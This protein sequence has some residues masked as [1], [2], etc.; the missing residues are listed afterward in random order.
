[1]SRRPSHPAVLAALAALWFTVIAAPAVA[2]T[3][4]GATTLRRAVPAGEVTGLEMAI[5]GSLAFVPGRPV[6]WWVTLYQVVRGRDLRV[7]SGCTLELSTSSTPDVS[8]ATTDARG[9]ARLS[10]APSARDDGGVWVDAACAVGRGVGVHRRFD[11]ILEPRATRSIALAA[12]PSAW[13]SPRERA[14]FGRVVDEATGLGVGDEVVELRAVYDG[15]ELAEQSVTTDATGA[16]VASMSGL[17]A[18][19][20]GTVYAHVDGGAASV[21]L[22]PARPDS[23]PSVLRTWTSSRVAAPGSRVTVSLDA[24]TRDGRPISNAIVEGP[25]APSDEPLRTDAAGRATFEWTLPSSAPGDRVLDISEFVSVASPEF[26]TVQSRVSMRLATRDLFVEVAARGGALVPGAPGRV[27]LHA[28]DAAGEPIASRHLQIELGTQRFDV[29]TDRAGVAAVDV[30][31]DLALDGTE[32]GGPTFAALHVATAHDAARACVRVDPD[33]PLALEFASPPRRGATLD[34]H[35]HRTARL[36]AGPVIVT[37]LELRADGWEPVDELVIE[38][39]ESN[40]S[41]HASPSARSVWVRARP[42]LPDGLALLGGSLLADLTPTS[43]TSLTAGPHGAEIAAPIASRSLVLLARADRAD[44]VTAA[45]GSM[46]ASLSPESSRLVELGLAAATPRDVGAPALLRDGQV[47]TVPL[48]ETP[49]ETGL[50]RDPWRRRARFIRGR[51]GRVF[52]SLEATIDSRIPDRLGEV[53]TRVDGHWRWNAEILETAIGEGGIDDEG[54]ATLDGAPLDLAALERLSPGFDFDRVARRLTRARL[55]RVIQAVRSLADERDLDLEWARMGDPRTWI[56]SLASEGL[57]RDALYDAWGRPFVFRPTRRTSFLPAASGW[58]VA[59]LG[60]DGRDGTPDDLWDPFAPVLALDSVYAEAVGEAALVARLPGTS[61]TRAELTV[62]QGDEEQPWVVEEASAALDP[63]IPAPLEPVSWPAYGT[64]AL[65]FATLHALDGA[66]VAWPLPSTRS[67]YVAAA[68]TFSADG[69][70]AARTRFQAGAPFMIATRLPERIG[71]G[72]EL[73][74][75]VTLVALDGEAAP[76]LSIDAP[77]GTVAWAPSEPDA[78]ASLSTGRLT[79]HATSEAPIDVAVHVRRGDDALSLRATLH[80]HARGLEQL[81]IRAALLRG[82]LL[83]VHAPVPRDVVAQERV[84][85]LVSPDQLDRLDLFATPPSSAHRAILAWARATRAEFDASLVDQVALDGDTG[86]PVA[87]LARRL[88]LASVPRHAATSRRTPLAMPSD[89]VDAATMLALLAPSIPP[90]SESSRDE[91]G[92]FVTRLRSTGWRTLATERSRPVVLAMSA[93]ALLLVDP[94]DG[95]GRA[96]F[97]TSRAMLVRE[98]GE[99]RFPMASTTPR[100][101]ALGE[102]ALAIAARQA[103]D[104]AFAD[105]LAA[106]AVRHAGLWITGG[107]QAWSWALV[108][109]ISGG[110]GAPSPSATFALRASTGAWTESRGTALHVATD[111]TATVEARTDDRA[112][113][114][115]VARFSAPLVTRDAAGVAVALEGDLAACSARSLLELVVTPSRAHDAL[116]VEL[117]LPS[118]AVADEAT[119]AALTRA[120]ARDV[121]TSTPGLLR[122][123]LAA[124]RPAS[125]VRTPLSLAWTAAGRTSGFA[126]RAVNPAWPTQYS[127]LAAR[128]VDALCG[129]S[130]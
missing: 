5:D 74:V 108:A 120:G 90:S 78:D 81:G 56:A 91:L 93:A 121:Q 7:A 69:A 94:D 21:A 45:L 79:L 26:G 97:E 102:L 25:F 107:P 46:H 86:H 75:P 51:L 19:A 73:V 65:D 52:R 105:A 66:A 63:S 118:N 40:A 106:Q 31:A 127:E 32:C 42:L 3:R 12:A 15:R 48:P 36:A 115:D 47:I 122:F 100:D 111:A 50:L 99:W 126:I 96:L 119:V 53:A 87:E 43:T 58:E 38:A 6:T 13:G 117:V 85:E 14:V 61:L 59:S 103:G 88:A 16:F 70:S 11:A 62:L 129:V 76:T 98:A 89:P 28:V 110:L 37:A 109:S 24:R 57:E 82:P 123:T 77:S 23:S 113:L 39:S 83:D 8:A 72:D 67:D 9:R 112:V 64:D 84:A 2:Q 95:P 18:H 124:L 101:A 80:P 92:A 128:D 54:S 17:P 55:W 10:F 35:L 49:R 34:V 104:D 1:M 20:E 116:R 130:P 30:P 29:D 68:L 71:L 60:P 22:I 4:P 44:E 114:V 125:A 41:L 27:W 33:A